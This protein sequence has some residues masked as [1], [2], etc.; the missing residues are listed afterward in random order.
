MKKGLSWKLTITKA[1]NGFILSHW[2]PYL[3]NSEKCYRE[4]YIASEMCEVLRRVAEF[5]GVYKG[6]KIEEDYE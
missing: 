3:D 6:I 4:H 1:S 5:F 2:E